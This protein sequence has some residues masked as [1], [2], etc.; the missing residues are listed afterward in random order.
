V[1]D[2][3]VDHHGSVGVAD[4][5][6]HAASRDNWCRCRVTVDSSFAT[7]FGLADGQSYSIDVFQAERRM[8][9]SSYQITFAGFQ[10]ARSE[11]VKE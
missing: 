1:S 2:R 11:C 5:K 4:L 9:A 3:H 6:L 7:L 8:C 10:K